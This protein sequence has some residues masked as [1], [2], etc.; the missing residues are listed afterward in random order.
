METSL[1][2][3]V[4]PPMT[5]YEMCYISGQGPDEV[6]GLRVTEQPGSLPDD[7]V[8]Y[9]PV[10]SDSAEAMV[11]TAGARLTI[12]RIVPGRAYTWDAVNHRWTGSGADTPVFSSAVHEKTADGPGTYGAE[13]TVSGR[14]P[15]AT[16]G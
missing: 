4:D 3:A 13:V 16:T 7:P 8:T 9:L 1:Y 14:S 2:A 5:R 15:T 10:T 12:Q 6:W 11:Y